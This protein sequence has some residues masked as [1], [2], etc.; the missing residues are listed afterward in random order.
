MRAR[1]LLVATLVWTAGA[2]DTL[3]VERDGSALQGAYDK[4]VES[5]DDSFFLGF[6]FFRNTATGHELR[7]EG[8]VVSIRTYGDGPE[9]LAYA[10]VP[11]DFSSIETLHWLVLSEAG[12]Y[13]HDNM[14]HVTCVS[15]TPNS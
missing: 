12:E 10:E 14:L 3:S 13:S 9:P 5:P 6:T 7:F 8:P 11:S 1:L 2:C 15:G 4:I